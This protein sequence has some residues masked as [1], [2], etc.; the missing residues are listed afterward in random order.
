VWDGALPWFITPRA[1]DILTFA[2]FFT[3]VAITIYL[4]FFKRA[5]LKI[6]GYHLPK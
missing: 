2:A 6:E 3:A 1:A 5:P 4:N